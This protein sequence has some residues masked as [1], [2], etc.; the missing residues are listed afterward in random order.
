MVLATSYNHNKSDDKEFKIARYAHGEDY[1]HWIKDRLEQLAVSIRDEIDSSFVWRSFVDTGPVLERDLAEKAG[2]GWVGK[3]SCL[4]DDELGSF[5]FL[6][7][8]FCN[9]DLTPTVPTLDQCGTC[10]LCLDACPTDALEAYQLDASKCLAYHNIEKRGERDPHY[11]SAMGNLL[12]GCDIC[13]EVCPWNQRAEESK[14]ESWLE[15]FHDYHV[16]DF[17]EVLKLSKTQ[18][19][20]KFYKTAIS[21]VKYED[22]MRNTF[23]V[24][25][26]LRKKDLL[27]DVLAWKQKNSGLNLAE[28]KFCIDKLRLD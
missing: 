7:V 15:G 9:L 8:I 10:T 16:Q 3:N 14:N 4:I 11:W 25:G 19:R 26:N 5:I 17:S 20:K 27:N 18:Y 21:R 28:L 12:M 24:I 6:S 1:H 2:I 23:L 22:F 13:Q